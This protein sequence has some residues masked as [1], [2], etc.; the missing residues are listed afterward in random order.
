M[1]LFKLITQRIEDSE[2]SAEESNRKS[3]AFKTPN[4]EGK[5][6]FKRQPGHLAVRLMPKRVAFWALN[7][8]MDTILG[9]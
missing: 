1:C 4:E 2:H 8:R 5:L 3:W 6:A 7:A 9:V